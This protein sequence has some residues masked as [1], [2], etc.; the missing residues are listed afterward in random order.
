M[1]ENEA[2][3]PYWIQEGPEPGQWRIGLAEPFV[4]RLQGEP[5]GLELA[6]AGS[7]LERGETLGFLHTTDR[8]YDLP[9][10]WDLVVIAA[11][12]SAVTDP[13]LVRDASYGR[14]WLIEARKTSKE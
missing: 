8:T 11:N 13:R 12:A 9:D 6:A 10:P 14:G 2:T 5:T 1:G 7:Q 3:H 4:E